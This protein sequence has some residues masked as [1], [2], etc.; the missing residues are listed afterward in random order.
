MGKNSSLWIG[1]RGRTLSSLCCTSTS[2]EWSRFCATLSRTPSSSRRIMGSSPCASSWSPPPSPLLADRHRSCSTSRSPD[3]VDKQISGYLRRQWH[4]W[5]LTE[6]T[7]LCCAVLGCIFIFIFMSVCDHVRNL[8]GKPVSGVPRVRSI[9]PQ[10]PARRG[11]LGLGPVD[12]QELGRGARRENGE[13]RHLPVLELI[14]VLL[15]LRGSVLVL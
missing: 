6:D 10:H 13:H 14:P 15:P 3:A 8:S 5:T 1:I 2:S 12:L 11:R 7:T 9:Q 4:R